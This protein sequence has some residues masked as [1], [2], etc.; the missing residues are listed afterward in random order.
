MRRKKEVLFP[1]LALVREAISPSGSTV[2][3]IVKAT[4]LDASI[5]VR[6][7]N[8]LRVAETAHQDA[9]G[10]WFFTPK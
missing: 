2:D 10:K 3:E 7:L 5:V 8:N 1:N 9:D 4:G 6:E